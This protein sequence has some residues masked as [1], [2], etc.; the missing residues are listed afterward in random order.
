MF[1]LIHPSNISIYKAQGIEL[2]SIHSVEIASLV[3]TKA[4]EAKLHNKIY[5]K[6]FSEEI[7]DNDRRF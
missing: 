4:K 7:R 6:T 2:H 5:K 3:L 1:K